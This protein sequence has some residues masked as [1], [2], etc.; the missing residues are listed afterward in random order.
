MAEAEILEPFELSFSDLLLSSRFQSSSPR[1]RERYQWISRNVMEALGP[2][3]PGL[4]CITGVL[5]SALLRRKLLP[6]ARKLALLDP[7]K[8]KRILKVIRR[9]FQPNLQI[10]II[11]HESKLCLGIYVL[12]GA[13]ISRLELSLSC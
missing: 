12:R 13:L 1:D 6:M 10:S 7:D 5:G 8:R 4:L 2:T 11:E 3:G 9:Q